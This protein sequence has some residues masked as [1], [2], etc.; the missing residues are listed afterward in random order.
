MLH[1]SQFTMTLAVVAPIKPLQLSEHS[2]AQHCI[3]SDQCRR[4]KDVGYFAPKQHLA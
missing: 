4:P 1:S 2:T 3:D